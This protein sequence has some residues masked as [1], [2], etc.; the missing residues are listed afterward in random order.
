MNA[1]RVKLAGEA[2]EIHVHSLSPS[3]RRQWRL[4]LVE[5]RDVGRR[6][7][8]NESLRRFFGDIGLMVTPTHID[9]AEDGSEEDNEHYGMFQIF[10]D[11]FLIIVGVTRHRNCKSL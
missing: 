8:P 7:S 9:Q 11:D 3:L 2:V 6:R 1:S 4:R 5:A 10:H